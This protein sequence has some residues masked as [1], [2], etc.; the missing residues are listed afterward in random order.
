MKKIKQKFDN[1]K[2]LV[3]ILKKYCSPAFPISVRRVNM[4]N[5]LDGDCHKYKKKF[6]I[7]INRDLDEYAAIETLMHEWAHARAWNHLLDEAETNEHFESFSH[8]ASWGV[9]Y[10]EVY[11]V[12]E[13][14]MFDL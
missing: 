13:K 7:R 3:K 11:R 1:Y 10:S 8:D 14:H 12:Y 4:G 6:Y 5:S 9:A 2:Y